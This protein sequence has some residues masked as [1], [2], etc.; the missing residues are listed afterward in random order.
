MLTEVKS[1]LNIEYDG[2]V[3]IA[4]GRSCKEL[5]WKN[6]KVMWSKLIQKLQSP[7]VTHE[8]MADYKAMNRQDK[9]RIKDVGGFVG[10]R[11]MNGKRNKSSVEFR[12]LLTLD[13]DN[14]PEGGDPWTY[15]NDILCCA[16]ALY[17]THS[18]TVKSPRLRLIMP[19]NRSV[20][21]DEYAALSRLIASDI[22][23]N[24]CDDTTYDP[25]R[26]MYWPSVSKDAVYRFE[27]SDGP[28]L[29]VDGM[30]ARYQNWRNSAEWPVSEREKQ[31]IKRSAEKQ[32][33]PL[34][35]TGAVGDFCKVYS[36][37]DAIDTFLSDVY[38]KCDMKDRYTYTK[39]STA[40][41]LVV[42]DDKFAYSHHSTD[43]ASGI[44]CN[45]FDL[46]RI[47]KFGLKDEDTPE[48][49][50]TA[51]MPSYKEMIRLIDSDP[52]IKQSKVAE[53]AAAFDESPA[54]D[55]DWTN[56]L[57]M[58]KGLFAQT[59]DN[60]LIILRND[61][62]LKDSIAYDEFK[63][64]AVL[65]GDTPWSKVNKRIQPD[66]VDT[67]DA[68]LR[69]Y[70]EKVY[71]IENV[72]KIR[73]ALDVALMDRGFH[74][75]REYV[76]SLEWD[77]TK[78]ID[79]ALI[80]YLGAEDTPYTRAV[81]RKALIGAVARIFRPGCKHDHM[82]VLVGPQGCGKS[83]FL[84]MLG[85]K[86]FSD[87]VYT[88]SGKEAYEQLQGGWIIE[89]GEMA[90]TRKAELEQIKQF[91]SKQVDTYRAAYARRTVAHPR[92]CAF[93]GTTNDMEFLHDAT[94]GRRFW[95]VVVAKTNN[96]LGEQEVVDQIWAEAYQYFRD[97]ENWYLD[98]K[99]EVEAR[100][101]QEEHTEVSS[102]QGQIIEYLDVLLPADWYDRSIEERQ[103]FIHRDGFSTETGTEPR[104]QISAL[105]VWCELYLGDAKTF[106]RQNAR[107]INSILRSLE[108]WFPAEKVYS[109]ASYGRQR[110]FKRL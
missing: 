45:A 85:G 110:G 66:W 57:T 22:S 16:A 43:P 80:D 54:G 35:K 15:V 44:L 58:S 78:R 97:G 38:T 63:E 89:M 23:I 93:F 19:L 59:I 83:T 65:V 27:V 13:M 8:T 20:D 39:G 52:T 64:R 101:H 73:D 92:Q 100:K 109:K 14:V 48:D 103:Q 36:I 34:E 30:L 82:L 79:T 68:G 95:P 86:W 108:E 94:G 96:R 31:V 72:S 61:E 29:D 10:G 1:D 53:A 51:R 106:T 55:I 26:L 32:G 91:L 60:V 2:P 5:T 24:W 7:H 77:G 28:W 18:H 42:Y 105:E 104:M 67:D 21:S 17:S 33:D 56:Q 90:A 47:H 6:K 4:T 70:I 37:S 87:S 49:T 41:G 69:Y 98:Q 88:V 11:L 76:E 99:M 62:K 74:P 40:G 25:C 107:E 75:V 102:K 3:A 46:V 84:Q 81:T 50:R 9:S 71:K 12:S